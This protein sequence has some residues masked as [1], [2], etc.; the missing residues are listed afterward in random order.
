M[1]KKSPSP[2]IPIGVAFITSNLL[3]EK[4]EVKVIK[5]ISIDEL[6]N[7]NYNIP[8][9]PLKA[10]IKEVVMGQVLCDGL[11]EKYKDK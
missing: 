3:N 7:L 5:N 9:I 4:Y 11:I 2:I 6:S 10:T 8:G 1:V